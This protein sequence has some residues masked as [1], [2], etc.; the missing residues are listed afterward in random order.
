MSLSVMNLLLVVS[1]R[2]RL[3]RGKGWSAGNMIL[4]MAYLE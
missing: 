3:Y 4:V 2:L 1:W